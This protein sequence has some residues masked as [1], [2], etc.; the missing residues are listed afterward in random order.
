MRLS[1]A[2]LLTLLVVTAAVVVGCRSMYAGSGDGTASSVTPATGTSTSAAGFFAAGS[3]DV[4]GGAPIIVQQEG[5]EGD[6]TASHFRAIQIDPPNE[7]S[8]GPKFVMHFDIDNDGMMDLITGWNESQPVQIHL[9]RRDADGKPT[10]LAV[11][12]GGTNPIGVIGDLDMADINGDGWLDAVVLVKETGQVGICPVDGSFEALDNAGTGEV[13]ILFNPGNAAQITDGDAWQAVRLE[14]SSLPGRRDVELKKAKAFP[15][16]NGYTGLAVGEIDGIN[17][18]DIVVCYNPEK[19]AFYGDDPAPVNRLVLYAN[20]GG[21]NVYNEG[22]IPLTV[23]AN[24]TA[25][26]LVNSNGA[27][28][29]L[30]GSGSYSRYGVSRLGPAFGGVEYFWTQVT[31]TTVALSGDTSEKATFIAPNTPTAL[32]FRLDVSAGGEQDFTYVN[33]VIAPAGTTPSNSPPIVGVAG[34]QTVVP[35]RTSPTNARVELRA[36]AGD[37]DG[38][39]LTYAWTQV[40]GPAVTLTDADTRNPTFTAPTEAGELRFRVTVSDGTLRAAA[41]AIVNSGFWAPTVLEG[42]MPRIGDVELSDIDL[43][44]DNDV[45]F[46]YPDAIS[47]NT[48]WVR[49][50][51]D[52][53][54]P[55]EVLDP[56]NWQLRPIG[57][58]DKYADVIEV[59]D[60]DMD[61]Y[62]DV[63]VRSGPGFVVQWFR[64]PGAADGEPVFPPPD[65]VPDRFNFPWQVYTVAEYP[66]GQPTGI[67]IGDLTADG[68]NEIAVSAGG[69]VY[70]YD[71]SAVGSPYEQWAANFVVDDTKANGATDDPDDPDFEDS[72]SVMFNLTIVDLDG[73]GF[74]DI[75]APFDRRVGSGLADDTLVWFRNTLGDEAVTTSP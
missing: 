1:L 6:D 35:D 22:L 69:V 67:A 45:V 4:P 19:C 48:E 62:D 74:G 63:L 66:I 18:P 54:S 8:A 65:A 30:D 36:V 53:M 9:Q 60:V 27:R 16:F 2:R 14:R 28:V 71:A 57:H 44:G 13:E 72:G 23:T 64:H 33:V 52:H 47:P 70:W 59:G 41:L 55:A 37:P 10:F 46:T 20:P 56:S 49:N 73:D 38:D 58:V 31:G 75:V 61:G 25:P 43:D 3:H 11:T 7:T 21:Q 15:E 34:E 51:A 40:A 24:A 26:A 32:S 68:R 39:A 5:E 17:G 12:L 42:N 29:T 50:P